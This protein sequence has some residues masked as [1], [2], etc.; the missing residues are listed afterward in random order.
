MWTQTLPSGKVRYFERFQDKT[1]KSKVVSVTLADARKS[2]EKLA[3]DKLREKMSKLPGTEYSISF[4]EMLRQYKLHMAAEYKPQ[5]ARATDMQ[6]RKIEAAIG[7][8]TLLSQLTAPMVRHALFDGS[9]SKYNERLKH[10]RAAL[11]WAYRE[12]LI[13]NIDFLDR[14]P[15]MRSERRREALADKFLEADEL[16]TLLDGMTEPK[17]RLL[18]EFQVLSGLR[19]GE[20]IALLQKDVDLVNREITVNKTYSLNIN[21]ISVNAKT[22]AGNRTVYIQDELLDCIHRINAIMPRRRK[23]FFEDEGTY[24]KYEAFGKYLRE[25]TE[26]FVGKKLSPHALRHTHVALLAAAGMDL[27][28]IS[29]RIGHADSQVTRDVYMHITQRLRERDAAKIREVRVL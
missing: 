22:D 14:L 19:I 12:E 26:K 25:N 23:I 4:G 28:L 6:F 5:T 16:K 7:S 9:A 3:R 13:D 15:K 2:T 10:V 17:W 27:S 18:T 11:R 8:D 24:I 21:E 20:T 29:R 1:G